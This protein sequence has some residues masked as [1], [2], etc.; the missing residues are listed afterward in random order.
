MR[1]RLDLRVGF[2]LGGLAPTRGVVQLG[3]GSVVGRAS[4]L[5]FELLERRISRF[6]VARLGLTGLRRLGERLLALIGE[7]ERELDLPE[8]SSASPLVGSVFENL[9]EPE[10]E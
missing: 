7:A 10:D 1:A 2:G 5:G 3:P 4:P 9:L 6:A 8:P